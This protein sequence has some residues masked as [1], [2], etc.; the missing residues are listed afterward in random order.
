MKIRNPNNGFAQREWAHSVQ[1]INGGTARYNVEPD[2][3]QMWRRIRQ[4][5]NP[6]LSSELLLS[7]DTSLTDSPEG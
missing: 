7:R 6:S 1:W 2:V 3:A 4:E 5:G